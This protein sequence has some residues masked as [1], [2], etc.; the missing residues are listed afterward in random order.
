MSSSPQGRPERRGV[1]G[2]SARAAAATATGAAAKVA[3]GA[4][5]LVLWVVGVFELGLGKASIVW[6]FMMGVTIA[7]GLAVLAPAIWSAM[8]GRPVLGVVVA[9]VGV[10]AVALPAYITHRLRTFLRRTPTAIEEVRRLAADPAQPLGEIVDHLAATS[11]STGAVSALKL[12]GVSAFKIGGIA[13]ER[14]PTVVG[15]FT[16]IRFT[17]LL[18]TWL[19]PVI[20][21]ATLGCWVLAALGR[22]A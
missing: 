1:Q 15:L 12:L 16:S 10:G 6:K 14:A 2:L 17:G 9:A 21:C 18:F 4:Q 8:D 19:L 22:L 7:V 13:E 3:G 5:E 11:K 20:G